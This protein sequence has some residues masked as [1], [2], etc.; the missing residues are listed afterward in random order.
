MIKVEI[1]S[2]DVNPR[3][4]TAKSGPNAGK[5]MTFYEQD[6]YAFTSDDNGNPRPYPQRITLNIDVERNQQPYAPGMYVVCPSSAFVDRFNNLQL[7]RLKLR[8]VTQ[9]VQSAP[10]AA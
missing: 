1:K 4:I 2:T 7:G 5:T 3:E 8:P 10:K 9:P 6:G